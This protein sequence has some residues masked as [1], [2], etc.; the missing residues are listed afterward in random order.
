MPTHTVAE[1]VDAAWRGIC[2]R[3]GGAHPEDCGAVSDLRAHEASGEAIETW[4]LGAGGGVT[5]D[6]PAGRREP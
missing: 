3:H 6:G 2:E 5:A 4:Y 1:A